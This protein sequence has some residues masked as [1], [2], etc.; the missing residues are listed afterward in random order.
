MALA[1][2]AFTTP[3]NTV[4]TAD[5]AAPPGSLP[6]PA[7]PTAPGMISPLVD[8]SSAYIWSPN[9]A[10]NQTVTFVSTFD[11]GALPILSLALPVTAYFAYAANGTATVTA[12]LEVVNLLGIVTLSVPLFNDSNT[13][14]SQDVATA[15][16]DALI[17][18]GLLGTARV[19]VS[20]TVTSPTSEGRYLGQL[21]VRDFL[22]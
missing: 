13:G 3:A 11:L 7:V 17:S 14:D 4:V 2:Q 15:S 16:G 10:A 5:T 8:D 12:T 19:V 6:T 22:L 9:A 20:T 1:T 21:T 18:A